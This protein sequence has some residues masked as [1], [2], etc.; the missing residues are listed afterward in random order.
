MGVKEVKQEECVNKNERALME[1][2]E[3]SEV[4]Q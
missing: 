3:A 2:D 1:Q 4:Q